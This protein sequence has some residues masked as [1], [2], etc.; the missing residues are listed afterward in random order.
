MNKVFTENGWKDYVYWQTKDRKTLKK[1]TD[2]WM[3]YQGM[4]IPALEKRNH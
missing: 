2:F 1:L 4:G 3:T